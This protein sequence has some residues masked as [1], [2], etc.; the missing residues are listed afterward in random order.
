MARLKPW[1]AA[2]LLLGAATSAHAEVVSII[3]GAIAYFGAGAAGVTLGEVA[4][5]TITYGELAFAAGSLLFGTINAKNKAR[6]AEAAA[7]DAANSSLTDRL[8]TVLST[9]APWQV[10]YGQA[11]VGGSIEGELTSGDHDQYKHLVIVL[12]AHQV[13]AIPDVLIAGVSIGALDGAGNVTTGK[14]FKGTTATVTEDV[15]FDGAGHGNIAAAGATL[16]GVVISSGGSG[17]AS[18]TGVPDQTFP[19]ATLVGT[20]VSGGPVSQN[21]QVTYTTAN[22]AA[23]VRVQ[24]HLGTDTQ[25]ADATLLAECPANWTAT[26]R[27][28]GLA[29]IVV[30]LDLRES[31]FQGGP[32]QITAVV[33][34]KEVYDHR[35]GLTAYTANP[36]LCVADYLMAVYGKNARS[37]QLSWATVDAAANACDELI[38]FG[39]GTGPRFTCNGAFNTSQS[40][41]DVLEKLLTSMVGWADCSGGWRIGAGVWTAPVTTITD[42]DNAGPVQITGGSALD[43]LFN[44]VRGQFNDPSKYGVATDYPTYQNASFVAADGAEYWSDI[45]LP[46][47]NDAQRATNLARIFT[48]QSRGEALSY[49]AKMRVV[50]RVKVGERLT[51]VNAALSINATYRLTKREEDPASGQL[52]LTLAQDI[53]GN[54]D[55]ADAVSPIPTSA[56]G[57]PDLFVVPPVI[58]LTANTGEQYALVTTTSVIPRVFVSVTVQPQ[59]LTDQLQLQWRTGDTTTWRSLD[60]PPGQLSAYIENVN[61]GTTYYIQARWYRP[62]VNAWG[63]WR[64]V[65]VTVTGKTTAPP[66][67]DVFTVTET[68]QGTRL[69]AFAYTVTT[70]PVDWVGAEIRYQA[71]SHPAPDWNAMTPLSTSGTYFSGSPVE[72]SVPIATG[73]FTFA[74]RSRD[75]GALSAMNVVELDFAHLPPTVYVPDLTPPPTPTGFTVSTALTHAFISHDQPTY[76]QGHGHLK[77]HVYVTQYTGGALP[78]FSSATRMAEFFGNFFALPMPLGATYRIWIK[79]ESVDGVLSTTPAGGTNGLDATTGRIGTT[80]L[81]DALITA[82]KL[83][84]GSLTLSKFSSSITPIEIVGALP[85]SGN[86]DGRVVYLNTDDKIYRYSNAVGAFT[87]TVDGADVLANSIVANSL[88]AGSVTAVKLAA[89]SIA[90]GTAAIQNGA[91]VNAM[92]GN[93]AVDSAKIAVASVDSLQIQGSAVT[94]PTFG[95]TSVDVTLTTVNQA[96]V[97]TSVSTGSAAPAAIFVTAAAQINPSSGSPTALENVRFSLWRDSTLLIETD[98]VTTY[99]NESYLFPMSWGDIGGLSAGTTYNYYLKG[100]RTGPSGN[101]P[102][103]GG[104]TIFAIGTKR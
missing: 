101:A 80:D 4:F 102:I 14:W 95:A 12:A 99:G 86:Y 77:T 87:R 70:K 43:E 84:D 23:L 50:N 60:V 26:D 17:E 67:F 3:G 44:G 45:P 51:L 64:V 27:L 85:T 73:H 13:H 34:G 40:T 96:L 62:S 83:A 18:Y 53:A 52:L 29:Y 31:E 21:A 72:T 25:A 39:A 100:R 57:V 37:N 49:P 7:K 55:L 91:I 54:Y 30:R 92:I 6:R 90:V 75:S 1:M 98:D 94:V 41:D 19:D 76:A 2:L 10:I 103:V 88:A 9:G 74:C 8:A 35:S 24:K 69:Y 61:Q 46:F 89:N 81:N 22:G 78:V 82:A 65:M 20:L 11:E 97:V 15:L 71:G 28:R 68:A 5:A 47:T 104:S 38:A 42:D 36:A 93:L 32:P 58:G 33:Q 79:W 48:E 59:Y 63:D 16:V 56:S 66:A